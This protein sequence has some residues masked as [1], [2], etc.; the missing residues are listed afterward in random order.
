VGLEAAL[1]ALVTLIG[2][3]LTTT[4]VF[5]HLGPAVAPGALLTLLG[6]GWLGYAL[7]RRNVRLIPGSHIVEPDKS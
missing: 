5:A 3:G 2:I 1:A 7:A 4:G 6:G